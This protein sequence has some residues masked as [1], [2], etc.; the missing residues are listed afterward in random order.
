VVITGSDKSATWLWNVRPLTG[1]ERT[2]YATVEVLQRNPDGSLKKDANGDYVAS[3]PKTRHA[4]VLVKV[5]TWKG[6]M[7]AIQ[8]AATLGDVLGTLFS[9]WQKTLVALA[10]LIGAASGV[11]LAVRN[12][13]KPKG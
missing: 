3:K 12:W 5:G 7:I 8:N 4:D 1:G 10:A 13:G 9:S 11:W 2:L 6:F